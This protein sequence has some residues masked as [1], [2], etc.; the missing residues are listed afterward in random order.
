M[1]REERQKVVQYIQRNRWRSIWHRLVR[2]MACIVVFC[3]TY[4]LILPA[5]TAEK[6]YHCGINDAEHTHDESCR[7]N[8]EADLETEEIWISTMSQVSLT[9]H[10]AEDLAAIAKSQIG[11]EESV[12]NY[13]IDADGVQKGY[14]RY[15]AWY[16]VPYGRWDA[17]FVSFCLYYAGIPQEV[18]PVHS[19]I[20]EWQGQLHARG[21]LWEISE[22]TPDCGDFIFWV[23]NGSSHV[24]VITE[25]ETQI[26]NETQ[27]EELIRV[28]VV[29][30]DAE[31]K[32]Q[33]I[34]LSPANLETGVFCS[35]DQVQNV[36]KVNVTV[37][38][39]TPVD[40]ETD[41]DEETSATE[42]IFVDE[43]VS[44]NSDLE[45]NSIQMAADEIMLASDQDIAPVADMAT[46]NVN[47]TLWSSP[48]Q[49]EGG[50]TITCPIGST[51]TIKI[52]TKE[53]NYIPPN[54]SVSGGELV[55]VQNSCNDSSHNHTTY[56][57]CTQN[58]LHTIT[59]KATSA[60]VT[61]SGTVDGGQWTIKTIEAD[62]SSGGETE[63]EIPEPE[64]TGKP[65]YPYH[66]HAVHTGDVDINRL[67]YYNICENG[68]GGVG[69]LAGCV[70]EIRGE[71]GYEKTVVSGDDPEV[72]LPSDIPDGTYTI[73]EVSVPDG[74]MRDSNF[75]RTFEVRNGAL[76][77][78]RNI[79]SFINHNLGQL[80]ANKKADVEDYNNRIYQILIEAESNIRMY[81]MEPIDVLFVVDQSNSMLFPAGLVETGKTVTLNLDGTNNDQNMEALGL[82]KN[83]MY[84]LISDPQ[85]TSTVW[86]IWYDG[87]GWIYQDASYYA[88]AKH[89]NA[90]GY[91]TPGETAIF[92]EC[93]SYA[94]QKNQEATGTRSNGG[95]LKY[96]LV[97]SGLGND[98][99][100]AGNTKSYQLYTATNEYNRLHYLEEALANMIYELA[101]VNS[102]NRVT[103][104][105][106]TK[107]VNEDDDCDGPLKL[108]PDNVELLVNEVT[109]INTSG[110]TR[111]DI[112]LKHVYENHLNNSGD[113]YSGD[114]Q[115]TYTVLI[116][117]G[118]PVLSGG[119]D[120]KNLGKPSDA[121][122][123]TEDSV[124]AQIK[125]YAQLVRSKSTLMTVGLGMGSVEA[126]RDVLQQI[127]SN[128]GFY[129]AL[130]DASE[131]VKTMQKL[132]FESFK[133]KDVIDIS[134]DVIDE[135]SHSFY[136]IAW[137]ST[138][139]SYEGRKLLVKE[140][141]K[142]W[143]LLQENDWITLE[144]KYTAAGASDAAGQLLKKEDGTFYI[145]WKQVN[146]TDQY[147]SETER[148]AWVAAGKGASSGRT[149][150]GSDGVRDWILLNEGDYITTGGEYYTGTVNWWNERYYGRI[151]KN[152]TTYSVTWGNNA[153]GNSRVTYA[154]QKWKGFFYVKAKE[155]FIGG[156]AIQ[157]NQ[158]ARIEVNG[159][160]W[161][162]EDPT[163]NVRLLGLN[164]MSSEV[165]L[166]L[167]DMVNEEGDAPLDSLQYF[168]DHIRFTK[169]IADG[170][171][172]LNRF[173]SA[174][175]DG[176]EEAVFYLKYALK[177]DL[178][179][180]EWQK[181][182]Q[183]EA[184]RVE[185][186]YDDASS[187]GAVGYFTISL[188]KKGI[189]GATAE[190]GSH[191]AAAA[192][193]PSGQPL[194]KNCDEP[195]E[196][197]TLNVVYT[198]YRLGEHG[199]PVENVYNDVDGPGTEVGTGT[200]L[201]TGIGSV[202]SINIH[203]VHVISGQIKISKEIRTD[204]IADTDQTFTF[205]L[206][207][208]EDGTDTS[209]DQ[210]GSIVV[211]AGET[212]GKSTITFDHLRRGTYSVTEVSGEDFA[213]KGIYVA[214]TTNCESDPLVGSTG[215]KVTFIMGN[216]VYGN[217]VIGKALNTDRYTS[218]VNPVNGVF[219]EAVF[220][221]GKVEHIGLIEVS[222]V[223]DDGQETHF[224]DTVYVVLYQDDMPVLDSDG[225][226]RILRLDA[227]SDW[228]GSF[229]VVLMSKGDSVENYD[230]SVREVS[231]IS[232]DE[233]YEW[234]SAILEN[235]GT[236]KLYY[237]KALEA[238]EVIGINGKGYI[239][240][241]PEK[242]EGAFV[243]KN[244]RTIELP[245]TGGS[246]AHHYLIG[247]LLIAAAALMY[248]CQTF[249]KRRKGGKA[250]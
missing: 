149:M 240:R 237:E 61:V 177:R 160:K 107:T 91:R 153:N 158:E 174:T 108:T 46:V 235:N 216:S 141:G 217:N 172:I 80:T 167:G 109:S 70:F 41:V 234:H 112:A 181:L 176:L 95:G 156:N 186:V 223:W 74:Y 11:Y 159:G 68:S 227:N 151:T 49:L 180:D 25:V 12:L 118:A 2:L 76:V 244:L 29:E 143:I 140:N 82:N 228:K 171:D 200:A 56:F 205:V 72:L 27:Q 179:V 23:E 117:D 75:E 100:A 215:Q 71:N 104:T 239:V 97:G 113:G 243:I 148:V 42:A 214:E 250:E 194:T 185:Y 21:V 20:T 231:K 57:W 43:E 190:Y 138:G 207:R 166:Y 84:Y 209:K 106:F 48:I 73:T 103:L 6:E 157:T 34:S 98:L 10:W 226:A 121:A 86:C 24:A 105:R 165:T 4:A 77:S 47:L 19:D 184:I 193:Q 8:P 162:L 146:L 144:G 39:E 238:G 133:P 136:P 245:V 203:E 28:T 52:G 197:Y 199:R 60:S 135:I 83:Q 31:D 154:G 222:K 53:A 66:P 127:A 233:L 64:D 5:I 183:G 132:L 131:L 139:D 195:A 196:E 210:T 92:P 124:Y 90:E 192:C 178:T 248:V 51:V 142:E 79:G 45:I 218:Y 189:A 110:G 37:D 67:R 116:T 54:V 155:D 221:N 15:G 50:N 161:I 40:E 30:G 191:E 130:D 93:R 206:H 89:N 198:A 219:G 102:E 230:Y 111:Q 187:E 168:Y 236:T 208:L 170:S 128:N 123:T 18:L 88:K 85:G 220:T 242:D 65:T 1:R 78:S 114:P 59:I 169:L 129:C 249:C 213:V 9:G 122:S 55:S 152:G 7:S 26:N 16:G 62:G 58:L 225:N 96:S 182:M 202:E 99:K 33:E 204:L 126:G 173:D 164:K 13:I 22:K 211:T 38:E 3:T 14:T 63:E 36:E 246:G 120:L 188:E 147:V 201:E 44:D 69:A 224:G 163:V 150:I 137:V 212:K 134:G 17:M 229:S 101:D 175:A 87:N 35:L 115:Y 32:V 145:Q 94:D 119:S 125:G 232:T 241:Y 247:G 81:Q